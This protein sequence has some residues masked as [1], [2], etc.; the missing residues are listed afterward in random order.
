MDGKTRLSKIVLWSHISGNLSSRWMINGK[1]DDV[2]SATDL[3]GMDYDH[4]WSSL[5]HLSGWINFNNRERM[6]AQFQATIVQLEASPRYI[7]NSNYITSTYMHIFL[8]HLLYTHNIV[9]SLSTHLFSFFTL[10]PI[11]KN[12]TNSFFLI[13]LKLFS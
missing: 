9:F 3:Y 6:G 7:K 8:S 12:H 1:I 11:G 5:K 10:V 4:K 2:G 13:F